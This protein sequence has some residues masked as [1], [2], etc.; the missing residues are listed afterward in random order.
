[1]EN[2]RVAVGPIVKFSA[3]RVEADIDGSFLANKANTTIGAAAARSETDLHITGCTH[4]TGAL[5]TT[6]PSSVEITLDD[7][8]SGCFKDTAKNTVYFPNRIRL[9]IT[10]SRTA[11]A[12]DGT[13]VDTMSGQASV[14]IDSILKTQNE[15]CSS[16]VP[17]VYAN[18]LDFSSVIEISNVEVFD[19]DTGNVYENV[20]FV[21]TPELNETCKRAADTLEDVYNQSVATRKV[22]VF[23]PVPQL[24][25]SVMRVPY[26][27]DGSTYDLSSSVVSRPMSLDRISLESMI[28]N[29]MKLET[30]FDDDEYNKF[31]SACAKPGVEASKYSGK[32]ANALS[33]I[34][35]QVCPYR[36]DGRTTLTPTGLKMVA[37]ESWKSEASRRAFETA[38]DCDGSAAHISSI[39]TDAKRVALDAELS[40]K[41]PNITFLANALSLHFLGAAVL[42]ANAG[43]ATSAGKHGEAHIAGH[44][45]A[46]AL[47]KSMVFN[48]MVIGAMSATQSRDKTESDELVSSLQEKWMDAMF[49]NEE[50]QSMSEE[51]AAKVTNYETFSKLHLDAA[52]GEMEALAIEGTS[53]VSPS[54]LYSRSPKDRLSRRRIAREHKQVAKL[55]GPSVARSIS[56]LDV[57]AS[58]SEKG[59]TFYN[60]FVEFLVSPSEGLFKS[61]SL[62]DTKY[63]T[64]Q[65]VF[66]K[67]NDTSVAGASPSEISTS[68][69]ALLPLWKV[70]AKQGNDL[71]IALEE[72]QRNTLPKRKGITQLNQDSSK[73]YRNNITALQ[74]LND[75]VSR[76][77]KEISSKSTSSTKMIF[78]LSSLINN[79]NAV[80]VFVDRL[81]HLSNENKIAVAIDI[82]PMMNTILDA[83]EVAVGKFVVVNVKLT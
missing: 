73:I 60:S 38:D 42:A 65:L 59:H 17:I 76:K 6:V 22:V 57:G 8:K 83:D 69:F 61:D 27:I 72:V 15:K 79:S 70:D 32:V 54:L 74:S 31:T 71:D 75:D 66:C 43:D 30:G 53:P 48:A 25:K 40:K 12:I 35:C 41:F 28:E 2:G 26:G 49:S 4:A 46:L 11:V 36:I 16:V 5:L 50:L 80:L 10:T 23:E 77:Y 56:Q 78:S 24:S 18:W 44:A 67:T 63:A 55:I 20:I 21:D 14:S 13:V 7:T 29:A 19:P 37:A 33:T 64:A 3:S 52:L 81:R 39:V 45:I 51:D 62:R 47:P 1:M 34:V 68:N 58:N 9:N 82:L